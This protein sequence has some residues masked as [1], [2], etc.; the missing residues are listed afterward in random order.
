MD[1]LRQFESSRN[2]ILGALRTAPVSAA[3]SDLLEEKETKLLHAATTRLEEGEFVV[4]VLGRQGV[5]KSSL[6]NA[7]LFTRRILPIDETETTNVICRMR[8]LDSKGERAQ[9]TFADGR[10]VTGPLDVEFLKQ[11][12]DEQL[13]PG[14]RLAVRSVDGYLA[15]PLLDSGISLADT[16][17]VGSLTTTNA[18]T[19]M[20]FLPR[21]A[22]GIFLIGTVP[23][24]LDSESLF[25]RAT[26]SYS[27][28]FVF[29]Q[30]AWG[31]P[32]EVADA[33]E[34][35]LR[36][37]REIATDAGYSGQISLHVVDVHRALEGACNDRPDLVDESGIKSLV[38]TLR[39]TVS[40][41]AC[42][43]QLVSD[44]GTIAACLQRA[45][46]SAL[47]RAASIAEA[48]SKDDE[49]F[50]RDLAE[51][52]A[53]LDEVADQWRETRDDFQSG[54]T[55]LVD[56]YARD[57]EIGV[58]EAQARL[59]E[60]IEKRAMD[61]DRLNKALQEQLLHAVNI[62]SNRLERGFSQRVGR[63]VDR[64]GTLQGVADQAAKGV[65]DIKSVAEQVKLPE[66]LAKIGGGAETLAGTA[67]STMAGM[68]LWA[69][70]AALVAG[71]GIGAA[72]AAAGAAVPGVGWVIAGAV[73]LAGWGFRKHQEA[74]AIAALLRGVSKA[75]ADTIRETVRRG[76][77]S[78]IDQ[79]KKV[80]AALNDAIRADLEH[81]RELLRKLQNDRA[82]SLAV[83][84]ATSRTLHGHIEA[85][86]GA[87]VAVR[88]E[89]EAASNPRSGP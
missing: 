82:G 87:L 51:A 32:D 61:G 72:V 78:V 70:G 74:K 9:V 38:D 48:A 24:L 52:Y 10:V 33:R 71:E 35:N 12:T 5:G 1:D 54:C 57:V 47:M 53:K 31:T 89:T 65:A 37:L 14:N 66:K 55:E 81:Q 30:N 56:A 77:Q 25:L 7:L 8:R 42:R 62:A 80:D 2:A 45:S 79:A 75:C 84:Q 19:T 67:L 23:T 4:A 43:L 21:V 15:S 86:R 73:L 41:G 36:K 28:H 64:C 34:D 83:R 13:N 6:L 69:G 18:A 27:Q 63:F 16:P 22:A 85:L 49:T 50:A 46:D 20:E 3:L 11:Y 76:R 29:V 40:A 60:L 68:A 17:G 26:W 39:R 88:S 59:D 44:G 58:G